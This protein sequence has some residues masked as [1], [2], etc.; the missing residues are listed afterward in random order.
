MENFCLKNTWK[1]FKEI[2]LN[3]SPK[4]WSSIGINLKSLHKLQK[5][6]NHWNLMDQASKAPNNF[7]LKP[8][9]SKNLWRTWRT[10]EDLKNNKPLT[11][12]KLEIHC[13][14]HLIHLPIKVKKI[15]C[16]SQDYKED[17]I[18]R[19]FFCKRINNKELYSLFN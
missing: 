14:D 4:I 15:L 12:S 13:E 8:F 7:N 1:T 3:P 2:P 16:S 5:A 19:L 6:L 17:R 11:S 10:F 9:N 18:K